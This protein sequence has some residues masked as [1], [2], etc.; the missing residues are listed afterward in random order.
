[1]GQAKLR[2]S[3][4]AQ[5]KANSAKQT[6]E[7]INFG[8]FYRD[9]KDDGVSINFSKLNGEPIPGFTKVMYDSTVECGK[10]MIDEVR[11]GQHSVEA[12]LAQLKEAIKH[13]NVLC[14]G[15]EV[16]PQMM[17]HNVV[18]ADNGVI[19]TDLIKMISVIMS[20]IYVLTEL[21]VIKNDN[22]NG[23]HIMH[24]TDNR[25]TGML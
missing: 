8:A 1:M 24:M 4:I 22:Y 7:L 17:H 15:T 2:K 5:L 10:H 3:E 12:I 14:F 20:D 16:R 9:D 18:L 25:I 6:A 21:G 13:Y 11:N 19:N 23:L